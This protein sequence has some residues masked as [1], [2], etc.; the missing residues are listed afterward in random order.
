F[1]GSPPMNLIRGRIESTG[2][3]RLFRGPVDVP[4]NG[5]AP[6]ALADGPATLGI[7]PEQVALVGAEEPQALA[8][9][10]ELVEPG[11]PDSF[12]LAHLADGTALNIRVDAATPVREGDRIFARL[13]PTRLHL[14]DAA[15][16]AVAKETA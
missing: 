12:V 2:G 5:L 14:F 8:P 9:A 6:A 10:V 11:G 4:L 15:G 16:M 3:Q 1:V 7:R 13:S